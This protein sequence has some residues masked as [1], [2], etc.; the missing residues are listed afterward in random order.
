MPVYKSKTKTKDGRQWY[1]S[2]SCTVDG[3]SKKINSAKF[4]TKREAEKAES[5]YLVENG[6]K[7][8]NKVTFYEVA[9]TLLQQKEAVLK[10]TGYK[11]LKKL[12][13]HICNVLGDVEVSKMTVQDYQRLRSYLDERNF[14]VAYKNKILIY[15]NSLCKFSELFFEVTTN[16]PYKFERYK[17]K[18]EIKKEMNYYTFEEFKKFIS[19]VDDIKYYAFFMVLFYCGLRC[20]EANALKWS[21]IDF[22]KRELNV[23]KTVT[24]KMLDNSGYY[25]LT[26]PKTKSSIRILPIANIPYNALNTL[27]DYYEKF[28]GFNNEWFVFGGLKAIPETTIQKAKNKYVKLSG[29]KNIR[30][31]DFRHSC[32]SLLINS[33]ANISLVSKYLGHSNIAMT[34]NIYTHFYKSDMEDLID[35]LNKMKYE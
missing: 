21:D 16:V 25:L 19:V 29:C 12:M 3:K 10:T 20:G 23:N 17:N 35:T 15:L 7:P 26:A 22:E 32:A 14:S 1:Y 5:L 2:I 30:I 34:L 24:T 8:I 9:Q 4:A 31:H 28:E 27:L 33:G 6:K 11:K 13:D 18:E